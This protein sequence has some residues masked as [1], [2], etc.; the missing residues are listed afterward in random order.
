ME[1]TFEN[2]LILFFSAA[3]VATAIIMITRRN[4]IKSVLF[5]VVNF[6]CIS[7]IY[8]LLRAQFIAIINVIVYAGAIMVLFLFVIMLLNLQDESKATGGRHNMVQTAIRTWANP[9]GK[10]LCSCDNRGKN[11]QDRC[12]CPR[13]YRDPW[14]LWGWDSYRK[15]WVYGYSLYELTAYSPQHTCQLPLVVSIADCNRHDSV[16][17]LATLYHGRETF[18]LPIRVASLDAAHDA[19]GL[20]R[21]ATQRWQ[22]ALVIPLNERNKDHLRYAGP[23]CLDNGVPICPAGLPMKS[24]GFCPDRL[25]IKWRCPLAA[26]NKTPDITTC[27]LFANGCSASSYGRVIYTYPK[28]NYRLH[29]LIP[30]DSALWKVHEDARSCAE[31]SVKRKKYDFLLLQTRTAGR[32]RWFFRVLLAAMCQHIDAW[33][34]YAP[35]PLN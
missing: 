8:L 23:L 33:L 16:H 28:Q 26:A 18:D 14:A 7:A 25:R 10:K 27:S 20:F 22:M 15:C 24:W 21:L 4:P 2:I 13:A 32:D 3:A 35:N 29:T 31:R 9:H 19:I 34:I 11:P 1:F 12:R 6:F 30:R 17:S 5:L